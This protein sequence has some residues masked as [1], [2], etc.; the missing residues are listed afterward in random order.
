MLK[1]FHSGHGFTSDG[2]AFVVGH[3]LYIDGGMLDGRYIGDGSKPFVQSDTTYTIDLSKSWK[4]ESVQI[5]RIRK[6]APTTE[7][8]VYFFDASSST[9]YGWGGLIGKNPPPSET[10]LQ[11][12]IA[13]DGGGSWSIETESESEYK[14]LSQIRRSHGGAVAN[15]PQSSFYFGGVSEE[16]LNIKA[17]TNLPGYSQFDFKSQQKSWVQHDDSPYSSSRTIY[18]ATAH[19]VPNFGPNGLIILIGGAEYD[20]GRGEV[21]NLSLEMMWFLDPITHKCFVFGGNDL[22]VVPYDDVWVLSLPGFFWTQVS[23]QPRNGTARTYASCALAGN[24]QMIVIGGDPKT[25]EKDVFPQGL[26]IF[27][28]VDLM[29]KNEY[30]SAA[31]SYDSPRVIK[32][33]YDDGKLA[34]VR[35]DEGVEAIMSQSPSPVNDTTNAESKEKPLVAGV[36]AGVVVGC[37]SLMALAIAA[38]YFLRK[39]RKQRARGA[40]VAPSPHESTAIELSTTSYVSEL[41]V[42][43]QNAELSGH[44]ARYDTVE[45]DASTT[46]QDPRKYSIMGRETS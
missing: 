12:F 5:G 2:V 19:Y 38:A 14:G 24:R 21:Q 29:W 34:R 28:T 35:Y 10:R 37:V 18:A 22:D 17:N 33:W 27:D 6:N 31:A 11:K 1:T 15:T 43:Q 39:Q 23:S 41:P 25:K 13:E 26:A 20:S 40:S 9:V 7:R 30:E 36:I 44:D 42:K 46:L 32:S 16:I 45:L 4:P 3:H 8:Q